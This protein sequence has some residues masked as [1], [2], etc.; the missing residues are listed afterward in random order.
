MGEESDPDE[1]IYIKRTP[2]GVLC[3]CH[4]VFKERVP[5]REPQGHGAL[6]QDRLARPGAWAKQGH[7]FQQLAR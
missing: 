5:V 2:T 3:T 7:L 6:S 1:M 4:W